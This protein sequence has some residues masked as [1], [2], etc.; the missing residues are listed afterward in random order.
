RLFFFFLIWPAGDLF[1]DETAEFV[2]FLRVFLFATLAFLE[3][4]HWT[5]VRISRTYLVSIC[6]VSKMTCTWYVRNSSAFLWGRYDRPRA[7]CAG[8][9]AASRGRLLAT[10][11]VKCQEHV[12]HSS[13]V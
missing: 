5:Y 10:K 3:G 11:C 8:Y 7:G 6:Y 12:V 9:S 1:F 13:A 4:F 2:F